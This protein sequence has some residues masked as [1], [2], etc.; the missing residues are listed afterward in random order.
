[1]RKS[2]GGFTI[3]ELL[4]VIVVIAILAAITVVAYNG[5]QNRANDSAVQSDLR[6]AG[7]K[8]QEYFVTNGSLP[9][10][11]WNT[12]GLKATYGAYGAHYTPAGSNGY[13]FLYCFTNAT[14]GPFGL[15]AASK[16]GN[17]Y[18]YREGGVTAG[19]GPL[20]SWTTTCTNNSLP[21]GGL[22][23]FNNGTWQ[24]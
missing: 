11:N 3:V 2:V 10:S 4:I 7:M 21:A 13:N 9:T 22:W 18:V 15:V 14:T 16:S 19:V 1:M 6:N 8:I 24:I 20:T 23:L 5:I 12:V 17:V